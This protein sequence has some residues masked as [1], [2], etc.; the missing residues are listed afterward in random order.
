MLLRLVGR[1]H[2]VIFAGGAGHLNVGSEDMGHLVSPYKDR[3]PLDAGFEGRPVTNVETSWINRI[4]GKKES[5]LPVVHS[6]GRSIVTGNRDDIEYAPTEIKRRLL[7][8]PLLDSEKL[9]YLGRARAHNASIRLVFKLG[10][11]TRV[12]TMRMRVPHDQ[13]YSRFATLV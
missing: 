1:A 3:E 13:R 4:A 11:P 7:R 8:R 10:I 5:G 2:G 6:N 9:L 12:V